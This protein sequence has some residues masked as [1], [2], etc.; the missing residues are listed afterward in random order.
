MLFIGGSKDGQDIDTFASEVVFAKKD[1]PAQEERYVKITFNGTDS[2]SV[3]VLKGL[4][5]NTEE[6]LARVI[7]EAQCY[8]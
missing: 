8:L 4:H 5:Y 7:K 1:N 6:I 3:M 2:T